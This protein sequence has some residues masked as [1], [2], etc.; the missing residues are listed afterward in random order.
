MKKT[1]GFT[2]AAIFLLSAQSFISAKAGDFVW[3]CF[4]PEAFGKGLRIIKAREPGSDVVIIR[5]QS[6]QTAIK[7]T[8]TGPKIEITVPNVGRNGEDGIMV[9]RVYSDSEGRR[10]IYSNW[11]AHPTFK[12]LENNEVAIHCSP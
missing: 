4:G 5:T 2:A 8:A 12:L 10:W 9:K 11:D 7:L 6:N 3:R 1:L